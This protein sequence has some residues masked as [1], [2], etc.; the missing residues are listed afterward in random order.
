MQDK[1]KI[2]VKVME[3]VTDT[4]LNQLIEGLK[5]I[6]GFEFT[7]DSFTVIS[8]NTDYIPYIPQS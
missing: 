5:K 7:L 1:K 2:H 3:N 8:T 4:E 6:N